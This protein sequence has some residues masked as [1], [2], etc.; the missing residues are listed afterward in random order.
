M[1]FLFDNYNDS[2]DDLEISKIKDLE[3]KTGN[4]NGSIKN[5][6]SP[7]RSESP[8]NIISDLDSSE[9]REFPRR[10]RSRND[11]ELDIAR[12]STLNV[13]ASQPG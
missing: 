3:I 13:I 9:C 7:E 12:T 11:I 10:K 6:N 4:C 1:A 2:E 5:L 8:T